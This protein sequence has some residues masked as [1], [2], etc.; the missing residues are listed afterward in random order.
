MAYQAQT[1]TAY[2]AQ[3]FGLSG[4]RI[5]RINSTFNDMLGC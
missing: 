4:A 3:P 1:G 5:R 2:Q